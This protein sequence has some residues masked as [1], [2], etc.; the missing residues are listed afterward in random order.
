MDTEIAIAEAVALSR[1]S[2]EL[3][4]EQIYTALVEIGFERKLAARLVECRWRIA[5]VA[6]Q[7]LNKG[8]ELENIPFTPSLVFGGPRMGLLGIL[9]RVRS[10]G[11]DFGDPSSRPVST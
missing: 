8:A 11:G 2:P 10:H 6:N 7:L 4:D 1:S 5:A 9:H 3:D